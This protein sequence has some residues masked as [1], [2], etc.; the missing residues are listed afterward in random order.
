MIASLARINSCELVANI[1]ILFILEHSKHESVQLLI[2]LSL[3]HLV[4][5]LNVA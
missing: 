5:A 1:R 4:T 2:K 3:I